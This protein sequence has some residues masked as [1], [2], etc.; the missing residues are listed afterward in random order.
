MFAAVYWKRATKAGAYACVLMA[1]V[2]WV[3]LFAQSGYGANRGFLFLG[4]MPVATIVVSATLALVLVS[5]VT[6]PPS[7]A[8]IEK[9]FGPA[10]LPTPSPA[11]AR[12]GQ[13]TPVSE[14][15]GRR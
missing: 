8:T 1:A 4:M 5:L 7:A 15:A 11:A 14:P 6:S 12:L 13:G 9:F 2:L 10:S 3:Y